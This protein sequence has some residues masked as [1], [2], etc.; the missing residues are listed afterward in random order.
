M[1]VISGHLPLYDKEIKDT[2]SEIDEPREPPPPDMDLW[3]KQNVEVYKVI[4]TKYEDKILLSKKSISPIK[5]SPKNSSRSLVSKST[6]RQ[7]TRNIYEDLHKPVKQH[8]L[9]ESPPN[10]DIEENDNKMRKFL[11]KKKRIENNLYQNKYNGLARGQRN[12]RRQDNKVLTNIAINSK[13]QLMKRKRVNIENLPVKVQNGPEIK[14]QGM[15]RIKI[16]NFDQAT[17]EKMLADPSN[18]YFYYLFSNWRT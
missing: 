17:Y 14:L 10:A 4:P 18:H 12:V 3:S 2:D 7:P 6:Q 13:G 15:K 1:R 8:P 11:A 16:P 9:K 5:P